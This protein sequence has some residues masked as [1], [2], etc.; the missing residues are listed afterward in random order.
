MA[1]MAT[2]IPTD[3]DL[4]VR[5][6]HATTPQRLPFAPRIEVRAYQLERDAGNLLIYSTG[7]LEDDLDALQERGGVERQYLNHWHEA[8]FGVAPDALDAR[9]LVHDADRAQVAARTGRRVLTFSRR[10]HL[11]GDLAV[12]PTPGH[13]P[14]AT[15]YLWDARDLRL[16]FTGDT[17]YLDGDDWVAAVLDGSDRAAYL[18]S[19]EVIRELD[20]DVLVPW[21]ATEGG[22]SVA[23]VSPAGRR[24]RVD[25]LIARLRRGADR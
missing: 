22:P 1:V 3:D 19:L 24:R 21:G 16:L 20:F 6:L 11:G 9:L 23:A 12:I 7:A 13:T 10:H 8:L 2:T 14:G 25:D 17:L 4:R 18:D 5:G 15:A